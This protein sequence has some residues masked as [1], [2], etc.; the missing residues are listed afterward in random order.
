MHPELFRA[1]ILG[2]EIVFHSYGFVLG[3]ALFFSVLMGVSVA[4]KDGIPAQRTRAFGVIVIVAGYVFGHI[5]SVLTD[6]D[7]GVRLLSGVGFTFYVSALAGAL[8]AYPAC[9]LLGLSY[10]KMADAAAPS[11]SLAHGIGRIGC[12]LYG[13]CYG[14]ASP[15]GVSF[16][17]GSPAWADQ[18]KEGRISALADQSLPVIP[19]QLIESAY[20]LLLTVALV[21]LIRR[22]PRLGT[23]GLVYLAAYGPLRVLVEQLRADP[24]R[25]E[26]LGVTTSTFI[27]IA[28]TLLAVIF[29][30]VPRLVRLRPRREAGAPGDS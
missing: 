13:C 11:V 9:R 28:T 3:L 27:G 1:S 15:H 6:P 30:A 22:R 17:R 16:P 4:E 29:L 18:V 12:F 24:G 21:W 23:A 7:P 2:H 20:E 26:I 14:I 8:A 10:L 25:G 19:T 5:H